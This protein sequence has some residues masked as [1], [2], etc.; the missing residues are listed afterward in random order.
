MSLNLDIFNKTNFLL[1]FEI[2]PQPSWDFSPINLNFSHKKSSC[3]RDW[4]NL[5]NLSSEK[6]WK[7]FFFA[8]IEG[9]EEE[10]RQKS[11]WLEK[12]KN[13]WEGRVFKFINLIHITKFTSE[14][15]VSVVFRNMRLKFLFRPKDNK[16]AL[17]R[18]WRRNRLAY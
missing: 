4:R 1:D 12:R 17:M 14:W 13:S 11:K 9:S 16:M 8:W 10:S 3:L 18:G 7:N 5:L 15:V 6:I 2:I